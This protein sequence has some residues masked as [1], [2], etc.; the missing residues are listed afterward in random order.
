MKWIKNIENDLVN[1]DQ[2][3]CV[4]LYD[5]GTDYT[6][7]F[8]IVSRSTSGTEY[9]LK[10]YRTETAA[11]RFMRLLYEQNAMEIKE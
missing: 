6:E 11:N 4:L 10:K 9:T 3:E 5:R 7:R 8:E 2:V 1:L